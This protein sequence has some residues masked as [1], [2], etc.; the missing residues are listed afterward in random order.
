M[1]LLGRVQGAGGYPM[2]SVTDIFQ[3][4]LS[5]WS[6]R[7]RGAARTL[8][9]NAFLKDTLSLLESQPWGLSNLWPSGFQ[10]AELNLLINDTVIF[11]AQSIIP[12]VSHVAG[13][14]TDA[15]RPAASSIL[16]SSP[17]AGGVPADHVKAIAEDSSSARLN[18]MAIGCFNPGRCGFCSL[19]SNHLLWWR[20]WA[21]ADEARSRGLS[22][23][24]LPSPRLP[25]GT[26]LPEGFPYLFIG[27]QTLYWDSV[28]IFIAPEI[29]R[30]IVPLEDVGSARRLWLS[31][32]PVSNATPWLLCAITAPPGGDTT[33]WSELL[34]ERR[35]LTARR[36]YQHVVIAGDAN[37]HLPYL[38]HHP[39]AC[40]C[41]HCNLS[42]AD[43][44]IA[45][46]LRDSGLIAFNP[47][48]TATH[49]SGTIIDLVLS[50]ASCPIYNLKVLPPHS[51]ARSDHGFLLFYLP[52]TIAVSYEEGFGRVAWASS[53]DWGDAI[54]AINEPLLQLAKLTEAL[55]DN[56]ALLKWADSRTQPR[57]RRALLDAVVWLRN[58]WYCI[59]GHLA[60]TVTI[61][62]RPRRHTAP[63][64]LVMLQIVL[65]TIWTLLR[66]RLYTTMVV[67][68]LPPFS[69]SA[70]PIQ[71]PQTNSCRIC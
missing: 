49:I 17:L 30:R 3:S 36:A 18:T 59:A 21:T 45:T 11:L 7:Y 34:S 14:A 20:L 63:S 66:P 52:L 40:S 65:L 46:L 56:V 27:P 13:R 2:S 16:V 10:S 60:G 55:A 1:N 42:S 15:N 37:T 58:C 31:V 48:D 26:H 25:P 5:P 32:W 4:L 62:N 50:D 35:M 24:I 6:T 44:H 51:V 29:S 19:H 41:S 23:L 69:G 61:A 9:A 47:V 71:V 68:V 67:Q 8:A 54:G 43:K 12:L 28:G 53:L 38:V 70:N 22:I 64:M 33:F 39:P 57:R